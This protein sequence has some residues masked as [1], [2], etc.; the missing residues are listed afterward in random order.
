MGKYKELIIRAVIVVIIAI[1]VL[2]G[3][4]GSGEEFWSGSALNLAYV[5]LII[6]LVAATVVSIVVTVLTDPKSLVK[7]LIAV[8]ALAVLFAVGYGM[9]E[10][11]DHTLKAG[12]QV[13]I[14]GADISKKIGGA[15]NMLYILGGVAIVAV[16]FN[17]VSKIFK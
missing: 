13:V 17:E 14:V 5:L 1:F 7:P 15:L 16:V 9:A 11:Q 8:V 3:L 10:G 12:D 6:A 4:G 2:M